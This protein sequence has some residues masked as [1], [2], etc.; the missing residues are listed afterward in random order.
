MNALIVASRSAEKTAGWSP[1]GRLEF[2]QGVY[3]FVYTMGAKTLDGFRPFDGMERLEE[4]YESP[5]LFP[6]FAN[7]LLS[8][9]RPEYEA[10]LRWSGFDPAHPPEPLAILGV[11]EGRKQTDMI[12]VFPCPTRN[13]QGMYVNKFF[14]HGLRYM[15]KASLLRLSQL[16]PNERLLCAL[17]IQNDSDPHAVLLRTEDDRVNVGYVPRYL[18]KDIW[19]L[20]KG[21]GA[22]FLGFY[23]HRVNA[24]A[25]LQQRLLCRVEACWPTDFKPCD[26]EEFHPIPAGV[27]VRCD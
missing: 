20:L 25:P 16:Q 18:A 11:T 5:E 4:I 9:S 23:A 26:S 1:V 17:D 19:S 24:D 27:P 22:E 12:E 15:G 6:V 13:E 21:C 8:S 7:R 3:R 10:F 14:L 2:D